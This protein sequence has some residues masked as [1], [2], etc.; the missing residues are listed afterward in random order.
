MYVYVY[1]HDFVR[2]YNTLEPDK[3]GCE[4]TFQVC[5]HNRQRVC[6]CMCIYIVLLCHG[7]IHMYTYAWWH[8]H[9]HI[10]QVNLLGEGDFFEESCLVFKQLMYIC[11]YTH[12]YT[13]T[14]A[15]IC[16]MT[17]TYTHST[18]QSSMWGWRLWRVMFGIET[19][20]VCMHVHLHVHLYT[21][22]ITTFNRS[23][24]CVRETSLKSHVW[25][26]NSSCMYA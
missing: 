2:R 12:I 10:Q 21:C 22:M 24:C 11:M 7:Y 17:R 13:Y 26:W 9:A 1:V 5:I 6:M 18:G 3:N 19:A 15:Y 14:H 4:H 20:H 23:I 8:A 16:M 25:Y